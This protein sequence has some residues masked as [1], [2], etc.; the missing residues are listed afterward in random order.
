MLHATVFT[1]HAEDIPIGRFGKANYGEWKARGTAFQKGPVSGDLLTKLEIENARDS[2]VASSEIEGDAPTG[3]LTSPE[4]RISKRYI[5]FRIA[6]GNYEVHTCLNLLIQG[7]VVKSATGWRSDR[8]MPTSWDVSR[9][10]GQTAQI[11]IVDEAS[12][13]WGHINVADII[14]TDA[15]E[16]PPLATGPLYNESLRPQFHFTARQWTQDW[17]N[18]GMRE[19]GWINDLNGLIYY[20]GDITCSRSGGPNA[21]STR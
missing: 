3:T 17:L 19:E 11:Q 10:L 4:F 9:W 1:G 6:G 7:K 18:P 2:A 21:G 14:Q 20:E 8:L 15:P 5:A 16:E 13:D 12:G